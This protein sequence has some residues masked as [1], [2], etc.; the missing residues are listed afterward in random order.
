MALS[1]SW[2]SLK[3]ATPHLSQQ[4]RDENTD[5]FK[6]GVAGVYFPKA[7]TKHNQS[8]QCLSKCFSRHVC[9]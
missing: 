5:T 8:N 2:K 6:L 3:E 7:L 1:L 9:K 4:I